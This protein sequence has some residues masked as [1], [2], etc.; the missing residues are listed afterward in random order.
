LLET[1]MTR[2]EIPSVAEDS[3]SDLLW[4]PGGILYSSH[5]TLRPGRV[6]LLGFN[7]GGSNGAPLGESVTSMLSYS[8]NAYIDESWSNGNGN[9]SKVRLKGEI[10]TE[11]RR[12]RR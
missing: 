2:D 7:P 11:N 9:V 4:E 12:L 1:R 6:Y 10:K 3:L 8:D 5:E